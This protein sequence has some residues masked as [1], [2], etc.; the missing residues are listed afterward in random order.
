MAHADSC[1]VDVFI[2]SGKMHSATHRG[3]R[4]RLRSNLDN[5]IVGE[6]REFCSQYQIDFPIK[7][8]V[9]KGRKSL[10]CIKNVLIIAVYR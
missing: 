10:G 3:D 4:D 9:G 5:E 7:N 8:G 2:G 1:T 6:E